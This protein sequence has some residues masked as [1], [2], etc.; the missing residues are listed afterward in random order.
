MRG[1][2][3]P[4]HARR[5]CESAR[6][7]GA[8][9]GHVP[10]DTRR[11]RARRVVPRV[12]EPGRPDP[13]APSDPLRH[14]LVEQD[15]HRRR[16][17]RRRRTRRDRPPRRSGRR[18]TSGKAA[19]HAPRR[20]HRPSP[21]VPHV[22]HCGLLRGGRGPPRLPG[23]LRVAVA[24]L[25]APPAARLHGVALPVRRPA[26]DLPTW[27]GIPLQQRRLRAPRRHPR[28]GVRHDLHR[29]HRHPRLRTRRNDLERLPGA[30]RGARRHRPELPAAPDHRRTV[31]YEHL[32][33]PA[34][35][36]RRR[37]C[38]RHRRGRGAVPAA[39]CSAAGCGTSNQQTS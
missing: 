39:P 33:H 15:V 21:P 6:T 17:A 22:G 27:G 11:R 35:R 31:A 10:R 25:S 24:R 36:G 3:H 4:G 26:P 20:R 38:G 18:P 2:R 13:R 8:L 37:R 30:R 32:R 28:R 12:R 34:R 29:R 5:A 14:R 19:L 9:L 1:Q 7:R 23:G 16:C